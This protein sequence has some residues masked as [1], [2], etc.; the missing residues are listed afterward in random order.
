MCRIISEECESCVFI[1]RITLPHILRP[2]VSSRVFILRITLF[3]TY[4]A[5]LWTTTSNT[6]L[7]KEYVVKLCITLPH[8]LC[9]SQTSMELLTS[10]RHTR[11][12]RDCRLSASW[13]TNR[14]FR[15][16][17]RC[18]FICSC[19]RQLLL[20]KRNHVMNYKFKGF[21]K[22]DSSELTV[23]LSPTVRLSIGSLLFGVGQVKKP[24]VY[25][26][27]IKSVYHIIGILYYILSS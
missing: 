13:G 22:P 5:L 21:I 14:A 16:V 25:D 6:Q 26:T 3:T 1:L 2:Y 10:N 19:K 8:I 4:S 11:C 20:A 27:D 23:Q 12:P 7:V 18:M 24:L 17:V 9:I 15:L